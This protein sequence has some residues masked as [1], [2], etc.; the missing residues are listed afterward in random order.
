MIEINN[1]LG[2]DINSR[3]RKKFSDIHLQSMFLMS[4]EDSLIGLQKE[5]IDSGCLIISSYIFNKLKIES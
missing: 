5:I 3:K 4:C 1:V 2:F